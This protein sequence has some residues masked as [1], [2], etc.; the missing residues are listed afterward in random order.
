MVIYPSYVVLI[1]STLAVANQNETL[2]VANKKLVSGCHDYLHIVQSGSSYS[3][4]QQNN[5]D[6]QIEHYLCEWS[7][8]N[9]NYFLCAFF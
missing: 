7:Q 6:K 2:T 1:F 3:F 9:C 5:I 4:G 8:C